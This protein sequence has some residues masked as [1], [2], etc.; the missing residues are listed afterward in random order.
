MYEKK[1]TNADTLKADISV[2]FD[3][4]VFRVGDAEDLYLVDR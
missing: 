4:C 1:L 2:R 3:G